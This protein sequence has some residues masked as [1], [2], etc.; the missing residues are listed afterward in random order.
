MKI[1]L[2]KNI[3]KETVK[4]AVK[5]SIGEFLTENT[6]Q[7]TTPKDVTLYNPANPTLV[8]KDKSLLSLIEETKRTITPQEA[9]NLMGGLSQSPTPPISVS[10]GGVLNLSEL[11]ILKKASAIN[12]AIVEKSNK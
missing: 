1:E 7:T 5:E 6:K 8:G 3:I 10:S 12:K 4:Q 9:S 11:N 2:L